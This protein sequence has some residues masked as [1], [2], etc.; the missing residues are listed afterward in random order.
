MKSPV[1]YK[2]SNP[3]CSNIKHS[4]IMMM[5]GLTCSRCGKS[6]NPIKIGGKGSITTSGNIPLNINQQG[7]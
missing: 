5:G 1:Q 7:K 6:M 3:K 4:P 2:C